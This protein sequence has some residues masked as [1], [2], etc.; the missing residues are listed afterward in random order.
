[1]RTGF[2]HTAMKF[3]I[4]N[5]PELVITSQLHVICGKCNVAMVVLPSVTRNKK[6]TPSENRTYRCR[7]CDRKWNIPAQAEIRDRQ[8]RPEYAYAE[9]LV[10]IGRNI[11]PRKSRYTLVLR[12]VRTLPYTVVIRVSEEFY[13]NAKSGS[14]IRL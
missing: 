6:P 13:Y 8:F 1:M 4:T 5:K 3:I 11:D 14:V 2:D 10:A 7:I 12:S 9:T